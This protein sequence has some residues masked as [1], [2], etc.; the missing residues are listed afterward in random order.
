MGMLAIANRMVSGIA[1]HSLNPTQK[2]QLELRHTA[3]F[4]T[5][6]KAKKQAQLRVSLRQPSAV[7]P[8]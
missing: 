5:A 2:S 4:S 6:M 3:S 1:P 8:G 7:R